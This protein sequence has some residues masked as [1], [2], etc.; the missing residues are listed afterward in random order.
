[1][2]HVSRLRDP[3]IAPDDETHAATFDQRDLFVRMIVSRGDD[4]R[5][6]S[7]SANHQSLAHDHLASYSFVEFLNRD[8]LPIPMF[9]RCL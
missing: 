9:R 6:E 1:M 7:Q 3:L 2:E 4:V 5:R 8:A